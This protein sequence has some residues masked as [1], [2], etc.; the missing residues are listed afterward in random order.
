MC[1]CPWAA[2][3]ARPPQCI[4]GGGTKSWLVS[5]IHMGPGHAGAY[6]HPC[7]TS[8]S[9]KDTCPPVLSPQAKIEDIRSEQEKKAEKAIR[10]N[11]QM[12]QM[13]YCQ[14]QVYRGALRKVREK[15]AEERSQKPTLQKNK[16]T[17]THST[18]ESAVI[19]ILEHLFAYHQVS[20]QSQ[21]PRGLSWASPVHGNLARA[22]Q[23]AGTSSWISHSTVG[24]KHSWAQEGMREAIWLT[25]CLMTQPGPLRA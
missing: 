3:L 16:S 22:A 9:P 5:S 8:F 25:R 11:F 4:G 21:G 24:W 14:D 13:V 10:Q 15:Q 19:E 23:P 18:E 2:L 1:P 17:E 7:A 6:A 20:W 12:E